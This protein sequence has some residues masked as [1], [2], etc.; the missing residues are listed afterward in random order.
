MASMEQARVKTQGAVVDF[1]GFK[2]NQNRFVL[3]EFAVVGKYFQTQLVFEA[4][5]SEIFLNKKMRGSALWLSRHFHFI[6]WSDQGIPYD[7]ELI[8]SLCSPFT[9]LYTKGAEKV[10]FL[11]QFHNNV[12]EISES[13]TRSANLNVTCILPQHNHYSGRCALRSAKGLFKIKFETPDKFNQ[14]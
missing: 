3:K 8:R 2:D 13:Y 7:E 10:D 6:K 11:K 1:H 4:P 9:V 14:F 12:Q 5:Y